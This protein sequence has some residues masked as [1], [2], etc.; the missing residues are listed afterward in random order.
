MTIEEVKD[1]VI[2]SIEN[3]GNETLSEYAKNCWVDIE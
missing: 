2:D 1:L 3:D